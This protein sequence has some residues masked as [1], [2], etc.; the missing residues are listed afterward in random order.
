MNIKY[1]FS[2]LYVEKCTVCLI[3]GIQLASVA[4]I[5]YH[6]FT[7]GPKII[8]RMLEQL[9]NYTSQMFERLLNNSRRLQYKS[10]TVHLTVSTTMNC[11]GVLVF[12]N[13]YTLN[14][15]VV[16]CKVDLRTLKKEC[17]QKRGNKCHVQNV[18]G[19]E[20]N[21]GERETA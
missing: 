16:S 17:K 19:K 4:H 2:L 14:I 8:Y 5:R 3:Q 18:W 6:R 9:N 10:K 20:Q 1:G 12:P 13:H 21:C 11:L 7:G 15:F